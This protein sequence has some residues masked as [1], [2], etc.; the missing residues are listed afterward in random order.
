MAQFVMPTPVDG[1]IPPFYYVTMESDEEES[2]T[3]IMG[4]RQLVESFM[5]TLQNERGL[6]AVSGYTGQLF[7]YST[8]RAY[9]VGWAI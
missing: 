9:T 3:I 5:V 4:D 7:D 6:V 8:R 1:F 2:E